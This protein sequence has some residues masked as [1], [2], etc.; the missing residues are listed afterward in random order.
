MDANIRIDTVMIGRALIVTGLIICEKIC[1]SQK[2][3]K[4]MN[5][6]NGVNEKWR[7]FL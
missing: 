4:M 6:K 5:S 7:T 2:M 3:K 1:M